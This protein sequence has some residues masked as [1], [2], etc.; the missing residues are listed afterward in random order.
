[1][2]PVLMEMTGFVPPNHRLWLFLSS[3]PPPPP[4]WFSRVRLVEFNA[5]GKKWFRSNESP[6]I[7]VFVFVPT[8]PPKWFS[9]V[10][11]V[12]SNAHDNN[13]F[14]LKIISY[15]CFCLRPRPTPVMVQ[16]DKAR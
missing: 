14:F 5:H 9:R 1:M 12:E 2:S 4:E 6:V 8:P 7:P 15:A 10:R 13:C 11:L 16:Q 3:S